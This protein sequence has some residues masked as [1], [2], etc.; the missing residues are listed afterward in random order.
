MQ[1]TQQR[2]PAVRTLNHPKRPSQ[3][4]KEEGEGEVLSAPRCVESCYSLI[5]ERLAEA[6]C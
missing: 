1:R 2:D 3:T 5:A 4:G 6:E